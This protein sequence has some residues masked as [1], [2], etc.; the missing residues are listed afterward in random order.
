MCTHLRMVCKYWGKPEVELRVGYSYTVFRIF[1]R[2][3]NFV[4]DALI[5]TV[6]LVLC[7]SLHI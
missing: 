7:I 4:L 2:Y 6:H 5:R 3:I 1:A